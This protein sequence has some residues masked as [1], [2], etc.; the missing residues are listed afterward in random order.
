MIDPEIEYRRLVSGNPG[1][2]TGAADTLRDVGHDLDDARSRIHD[3]GATTDWTGAASAGFE[4]RLAQ[5]AS[6]VNVNRTMLARARGALDTAAAAYDVA[7]QN[8]DHY[9]SFWRNRPSGLLPVLE[10]VLGLAV[11]A[12]L[13]ETGATYSQQLTGIAAVIMG[14]DVDL[15]EL[16]AE[17]RKWVEQGLEKNEE[18]ARESGSTFGPLI[19]NTAATGDERGLTPQGLAYDPRTGTYVMTYYSSDGSTIALVDSVTGQEIG[20]VDLGGTTTADAPSHAGGVSVQ[21]DDV[22]VVDK[23]RVYTYSMADIRD[24][25]DGATVTPSSVQDVPGGGSYSAVHDGRL[26]L[27]DYAADK[28]YVYEKDAFGDWQPVVDSSTGKAVSID[29]PPK[30]QGVVVRDGEYVFSTSPNRFDEGSLIV[31]D[32]DTGERSDPYS[33]PNMSEGVVEVDG[34]FVT[35][36]ESSAEKYDDDGSSWGWVP[37]V[38]DDDDLW[39]NPYLTVTPLS[40][41]GLGADFDVKPGTLRQASDELDKP[42]GRL[43]T[44]SSTVA[45]VHVTGLDLGQVPGCAKLAS[46]IRQL[47]DVSADS[48]RSGS[49]AVGLTSD[50]LMAAA[51]D[52]ERSDS[53]VDGL[54]GTLN[55]FD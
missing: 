44:A 13:V 43:M 1:A 51:R 17:T 18:W 7:V 24:Q 19:P 39:S 40:S 41:L 37:G 2:V 8:A 35:L 20:D 48:L 14:D 4:A 54:F 49:Q 12:R 34:S 29:T 26:Y 50:N 27:G 10:Q 31:Q 9:I 55:P 28:L 47:L 16:D 22:I 30:A 42:A 21:G 38:P 3:A 15:D 6:G 46:A 52:Y 32:R 45:G 25:Q 23:G 36:Y 11:Q 53:L 5:L 33:L